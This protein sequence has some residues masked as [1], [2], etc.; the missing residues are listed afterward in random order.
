MEKEKI[1]KY[2]I[3]KKAGEGAFGKVYQVQHIENNK[4]FAIK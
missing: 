3:L 4:E 1:G 2:K